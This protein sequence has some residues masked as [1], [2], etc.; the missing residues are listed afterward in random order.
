MGHPLPKDILRHWQT[1][2][3]HQCLYASHEFS[4]V[5]THSLPTISLCSQS[6]T[7]Y[8]LL[9]CSH[10]SLWPGQTLAPPS[11]GVCQVGNL[12]NTQASNPAPLDLL[13]Q[14]FQNYYATPFWCL[15]SGLIP[16]HSFWFHRLWGL[17]LL[18]PLNHD[19]DIC[20]IISFE[21]NL[22]L[23]LLHSS[24]FMY[25]WATK[26]QFHKKSSYDSMQ[27]QPIHHLPTLNT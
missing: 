20:K 4:N 6:S 1:F 13:N 19:E 22:C 11:E 16:N 9:A 23:I 5:L 15:E 24:H 26:L 18:F 25:S 7:L 2:C 10:L 21:L 14:R 12:I 27:N 17:N 8:V 3:E